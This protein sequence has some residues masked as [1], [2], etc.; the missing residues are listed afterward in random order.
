MSKCV[1]TISLLTAV[2]WGA[3]NVF[4]VAAAVAKTVPQALASLK[5]NGPKAEEECDAEEDEEIQAARTKANNLTENQQSEKAAN[6]QQACSQMQGAA[7][8]AASALAS[9]KAKCAPIVK[10]CED[11]LE[12]L[13]N[14]TLDAKQKAYKAMCEKAEADLAKLDSEMG[15]AK[16]QGK[17]SAQCQQDIGGSQMPQLPQMPQAEAKPSPS[18]PKIEEPPQNCDNPTFAATNSVC[19]CKINPYALGC[20]TDA[21][22]SVDALINDSSQAVDSG[23]SYS[24]TSATTA[25]SVREKSALGQFKGGDAGGGGGVSASS[26]NP[27]GRDQAKAAD[28]VAKI[29]ASGIGGGAGSGGGSGIGGSYGSGGGGYGTEG[30][31]TR[32]PGSLRNDG[33]SGPDLNKFLP[34][35]DGLTGPHTDLFRKV[36][37]RYKAQTNSL[38][39]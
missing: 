30:N 6:P 1:L 28:G 12:A 19:V 27:A 33:A 26:A 20:G 13:T 4:A 24:P 10:V 8:G 32:R 9:F 34:G 11:D 39:P 18:P 16:M 3:G 38:I 22:P 7:D 31:N 35:K 25:M 36:R 21:S 17:A 23:P 15:K 29:A 37:I 14:T 2:F 5:A